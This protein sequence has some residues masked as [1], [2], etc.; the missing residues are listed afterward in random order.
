MR[1]LN[2]EH[3]TREHGIYDH[4]REFGRR[5]F[6]F[7]LSISEGVYERILRCGSRA[8]GGQVVKIVVVTVG[9]EG[10]RV[11]GSMADAVS[12][13]GRKGDDL[14][15]CRYRCLDDEGE[16]LAGCGDGSVHGATR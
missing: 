3:L 1:Q 10:R 14:V 12:P 4:E 15:G 9:E 11:W 2:V 16:P 5:L 6:D 7:E 8:S 13:C